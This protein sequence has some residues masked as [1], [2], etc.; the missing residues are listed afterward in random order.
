MQIEELEEL[1]EEANKNVVELQQRNLRI[2]KRN[3]IW[4]NIC[5][6]VNAVDKTRTDGIMCGP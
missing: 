3:A 2:T 1:A 4:D 6:K 5:K